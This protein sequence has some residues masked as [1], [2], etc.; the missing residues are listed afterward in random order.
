MYGEGKILLGSI[1]HRL[2][3]YDH[4]GV[5]MVLVDPSWWKW[6]LRTQ[7]RFYRRVSNWH[8][9]VFWLYLHSQDWFLFSRIW[10]DFWLSLDKKTSNKKFL[11]G[12]CFPVH[13]LNGWVFDPKTVTHLKVVVRGGGPVDEIIWSWIRTLIYHLKS[14]TKP[15]QNCKLVHMK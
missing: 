11:W 3:S 15:L 5:S 4:G 10:W 7:N 14:L 1:V 6:S 9:P 13:S 12:S 2:Q 8:K